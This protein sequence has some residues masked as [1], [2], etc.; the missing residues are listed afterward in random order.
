LSRIKSVSLSP[1]FYVYEFCESMLALVFRVLQV[2]GFD[3]GEGR[4]SSLMA[5]AVEDE[6]SALSMG[7]SA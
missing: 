4:V 7:H 3:G 5:S 6:N 2:V 1:K